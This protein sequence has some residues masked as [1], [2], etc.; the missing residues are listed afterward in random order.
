[1][2]E[3]AFIDTFLEIAKR[4]LTDSFIVKKHVNLIYELFLNQN[5][6][7]NIKEVKNPKRGIS[8]FQTDICIFEKVKD[9]EFP[10]LVIEFKTKVRTHDILVY[11]NKA[12]KHK[13][14]YP[15]LRY[16]MLASDADNIPDRFFVHNEH[17]D[18]FIAAKKYIAKKSFDF[19]NELISKEI[20]ISRKLE[21]IH[22]EN[23]KY[24][25]YRNEIIF[26]N[27]K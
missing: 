19:I 14:I 27:F 20:E 25:Y 17:L 9:I 10:R 16:G 24:D 3:G 13:L 5:L 18:F 6:E 4:G 23:K 7:L 21:E 8:A 12:G 22:F 15:A 11:S 2:K 1:M 26:K